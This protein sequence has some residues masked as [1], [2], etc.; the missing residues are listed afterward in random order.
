MRAFALPVD[1]LI[2]ADFFSFY[3]AVVERIAEKKLPSEAL[4]EKALRNAS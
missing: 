4:L 3:G 2:A 1:G